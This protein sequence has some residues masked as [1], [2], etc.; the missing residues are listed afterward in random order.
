MVFNS[1]V[2]PL[3]Y[4]TKINITNARQ[5]PFTVL[6]V[7][8]VVSQQRTLGVRIRLEGQDPR[9]EERRWQSVV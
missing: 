7:Q 8:T 1:R 9:I 4:L 6:Q 2:K 5:R 3:N